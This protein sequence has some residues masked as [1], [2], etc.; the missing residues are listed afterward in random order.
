MHII[1][2]HS[3][4]ITDIAFRREKGETRVFEKYHL[5]QLKENGVIG[6]ICVFWVEPLFRENPIRRFR[7][8]LKYAL[9]D[10]KE[11]SEAEIVTSAA[12]LDLSKNSSKVFIYLG[13]E[14]LSFMEDWDGSSDTEKI[15]RAVDELD[16]LHIRHS[17]FAWNEANFLATGTGCQAH[18]RG[19]TNSGEFAVEKMQNKDWIIDVSH[20]DEPSFWDI[21][22]KTNAPLIASHSNAKRICDHERNLTDDQIKEIARHNGLIGGNA[23]A[24]FVADHKPSLEKYVDHLVYMADLVGVNHIGLGFDFTDYLKGYNLGFNN[25]QVTTN[26]ESVAGIP[27]LV[28]EL[29][30]RGFTTAE[31]EQICWKNALKFLQDRVQSQDNK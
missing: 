5:P 12:N 21:A 27:L 2:L 14:G 15:S 23:H 18:S 1:D 29:R 19:L 22:A 31:V 13:L 7:Q 9:D 11:C 17:I 28:D 8:L 3:D 10:F 25:E 30:R 26:L 24:E 20:L 6:L 16:Q 4:I